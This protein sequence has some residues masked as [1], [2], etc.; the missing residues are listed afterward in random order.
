MAPRKLTQ[1]IILAGGSGERLRP[2]TLALPKPLVSVHGKPF[3]C[4][5]IDRLKAQGIT[6]V[7][8]LAGYMAGEFDVLK[9]I[10]AEHDSLNIKIMATS[11]EFQTGNRV[12]L[13]SDEIADEFLFCFMATIIGHLTSIILNRNFSKVGGK[14]R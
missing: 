1:A 5:L 13:A 9:D 14:V 3:I 7:L 2:F 4:Y 11:P 6:E 8:I 10:Y 12:L